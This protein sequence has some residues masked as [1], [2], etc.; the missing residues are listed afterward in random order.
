MTFDEVRQIVLAWRGVEEGTS[1]GT[2]ALKVRRKML[3]RLREDGDTLV[4]KAWAPTS[5]HGSSN[6]SPTCTT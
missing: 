6:R 5:A 4:V 1:Y 3:A 2:P